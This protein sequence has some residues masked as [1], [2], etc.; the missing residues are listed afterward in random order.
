M[1]GNTSHPAANSPAVGST[2]L[3]AKPVNG[4][5]LNKFFPQGVT[6]TQEKAGFSMANLKGGGTLAITDLASNPSARDKYK[7]STET[8][9]GYPAVKQG[10][11]GVGIL[12]GDRYQVMVRGSANAEGALGS[13]NLSGLAELK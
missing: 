4:S 2:T 11:Q 13:A 1:G 6:Y 8:V 9:A 12:V 10:S 3:P 7:S 5:A